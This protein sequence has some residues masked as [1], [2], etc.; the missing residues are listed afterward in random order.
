[1]IDQVPSNLRVECWNT[2]TASTPPSELTAEI[3]CAEANKFLAAKGIESCRPKRAKA[4]ENERERALRVLKDLRSSVANLA[5]ERFEKL[6]AEIALLIEMDPSNAIVDVEVIEIPS[7]DG[8]DSADRTPAP[9]VQLRDG[10]NE[11]RVRSVPKEARAPITVESVVEAMAAVAPPSDRLMVKASAKPDKKPPAEPQLLNDPLFMSARLLHAAVC[12]EEDY[13]KWVPQTAEAHPGDI[14]IPEGGGPE[15]ISLIR[16][17]NF[18]FHFTKAR[19]REAFKLICSVEN[20]RVENPGAVLD[21][22]F[23]KMLSEADNSDETSFASLNREP[24]L[25]Y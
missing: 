22:E 13:S 20:N 24:A 18:S 14:I 8:C 7:G 23:E 15:R 9:H 1:L 12:P 11:I 17:K 10:D 19:G 6:F 16:A 25:T 3:V 5:A 2:I 21:S 4:E